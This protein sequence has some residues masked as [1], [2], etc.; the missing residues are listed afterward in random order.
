MLLIPVCRATFS[1]STGRAPACDGGAPRGPPPGVHR[2]ATDC[3]R[4]LA[5]S[6]SNTAPMCSAAVSSWCCA[7]HQQGHGGALHVTAT[8]L[9]PLPSAGARHCS[10]PRVCAPLPAAGVLGRSW[11]TAAVELRVPACVAG[12][13]AP[14]LPDTIALHCTHCTVGLRT[15][16]LTDTLC[17]PGAAGGEAPCGGGGGGAHRA[18]EAGEGGAGLW[19]QVPEGDR[20]VYVP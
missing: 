15:R 4:G 17:S 6:C 5:P 12:L 20:S 18:G 13:L 19:G 14:M 11:Y 8:S 7:A 9:R 10:P 2:L 3:C 1:L 16:L